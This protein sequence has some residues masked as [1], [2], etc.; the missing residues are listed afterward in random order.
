[1]DIAGAL[2]G[3]VLGLYGALD[4]SIPLDGLDTMRERLKAGSHAAQASEIVVYPDANHAFFADYRPS[5]RAGDAADAWAKLTAWF[6]KYL[7]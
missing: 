7:A 5:Y 4:Q 2:N 3:P 6:A 1:M